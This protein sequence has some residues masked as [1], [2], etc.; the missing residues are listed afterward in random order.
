MNNINLSAVGISFSSSNKSI[1]EKHFKQKCKRIKPK[2]NTDWFY[3]R[4]QYLQENQNIN[5]HERCY[6]AQKTDPYPKSFKGRFD[7]YI[8]FKQK[9]NLITNMFKKSFQVRC[10]PFR[11]AFENFKQYHSTH[12]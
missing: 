11:T 7:L 3:N 9:N 5:W 6:G 4:G 8:Y 10:L 12:L 2:P 1:F